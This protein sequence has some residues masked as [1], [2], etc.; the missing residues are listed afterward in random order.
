MCGITGIFAFNQIGKFNLINL[1]RATSSMT[2]RGPDDESVFLDE[3]VG[4]GHRRLS[5]L[6]TSLAARQPMKD[7]TGR[8]VITFNGEIYN[9]RQLKAELEAKGET[10]FS[11]GDTEVLLRLFAHEGPACLNRLN[12]FFALGIFDRQENILY[13]A[14]DRF[15]IKPLLFYQDE[16]KLIFASELKT[17]LQFGIEKK[18]DLVSLFTYL[19]LN[20][21]PAPHSMLQR[22][23]KLMPGHYLEVRKKQVKTVRYYQPELSQILY[24]ENPV[25]QFRELLA[26][27][28]RHRLVSDVPL[29]T[30][31]S[32]GLDSS[33][34][35]LLAS[36]EIKDLPTFTIG[37]PGNKFYDE[38]HYAEKMAK[39]IG[40]R[41]H[42]F[43]I[44]ELDLFDQLF[45][46]LDLLDEPFADS[47]ALPVY[48]LSRKTKQ[49]VKVVLAGDGAD[50]LLGGYNKYLA[51]IKSGRNSWQNH[52]IS[53]LGPVW[54]RLPESRHRKTLNFIRQIKRYNQSLRL[55]ERERYWFL[56]SLFREETATYLL[57]NQALEKLDF[58]GFGRRKREILSQ[59]KS[60]GNTLNDYLMA[61]QHTVL[62]NDMLTKVD[63]MSMAAGLEVRVPFLDHRLV[64][65]VNSLPVG[66]K[67]RGEKRKWILREAFGNDLPTDIL[68]RKKHGFEVPLLKWFRGE[69]K[70]LIFDDLLSQNTIDA[71]GIFDFESLQPLKNK[72]LSANPGDTPARLWGLIVFQW[73]WRKYFQ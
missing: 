4:L 48:I 17:I 46:M 10:F 21:L 72:L 30:F 12:G 34:I 40:T 61:D 69:L 32:G 53:A 47:S 26:D 41:H 37:F 60:S 52:L 1:S 64:E 33:V 62:T 39:H 27:S 15:G 2:H 49:Q 71:Q 8:F 24:S 29:G 25:D 36:R 56:L 13:L 66:F 3:N 50:E 59:L 68:N 58:D 19:Q 57:H 11:E 44:T 42:S 20:Y 28:V 5:I 35:S 65:M 70:T 63:L 6:D 43:P 45:Q 67:I 23:Q 51:L 22:I 14:R 16:D 31:L 73:W 55:D 18:L 9:F 7:P 38:S 54:D